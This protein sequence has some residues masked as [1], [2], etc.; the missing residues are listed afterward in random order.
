MRQPLLGDF[1]G[2]DIEAS[3]VL[4]TLLLRRAIAAAGLL[5]RSDPLTQVDIMRARPCVKCIG[6][7]CG[8]AAILAFGLASA[9]EPPARAKPL[10]DGK[11]FAGWADRKPSHRDE[12]S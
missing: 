4:A 7:S 5:Y 2:I 12:E 8:L 3:I 6:T 9:G 1:Q 11:T 10:F